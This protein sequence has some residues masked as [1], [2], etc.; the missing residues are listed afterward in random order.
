M[1]VKT[2]TRT[3][4]HAPLRSEKQFLCK[5]VLTPP[6]QRTRRHYSVR[7]CVLSR[8]CIW[9][10]PDGQ[11]VYFFFVLPTASTVAVTHFLE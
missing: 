10:S 6:I 1:L 4:H 3:T 9:A 5:A 8:G 11:N 2:S 7:R